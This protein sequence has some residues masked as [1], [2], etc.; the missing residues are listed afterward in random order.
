MEVNSA[1][2]PVE[3]KTHTGRN[4]AL[5]AGVGALGGYGLGYLTT[6]I[7]KNG[8]YKD[9]FILRGLKKVAGDKK[10]FEIFKRFIKMKDDCT[11]EDVCKFFKSI[12]KETVKR[13]AGDDVLVLRIKDPS[14]LSKTQ[15]DNIVNIFKEFKTK[16]KN[17]FEPAKAGMDEI[18]D[19][20][21]KAFKNNLDA[22][23]AEDVN[24]AKKIISE[25]KHERGGKFGA[26]G[27]A[28]CALGAW[29]Y[30]LLSKP[31]AGNQ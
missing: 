26:I 6:T 23:Q 27:L 28:A 20:S 18:Y 4:V 15:A 30:S 25:M 7:L 29:A 12:D 2:N 8:D 3:T 9:E 13:M 16:A 31:S 14:T 17:M 1:L 11:I 19:R 10:E 24:I 22:T 5:G 21:V